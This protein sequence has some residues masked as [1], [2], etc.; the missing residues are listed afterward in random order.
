MPLTIPL[1]LSG[2]TDLYPSDVPRQGNCSDCGVFTMQFAERLSRNVAFNFEQK[3]M[4]YMRR[5]V[6]YEILTGTLLPFK[7]AK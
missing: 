7:P 6:L 2:W 1:F 3:H 4:P 5:R